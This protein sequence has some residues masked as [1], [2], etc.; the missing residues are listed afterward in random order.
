M[1]KNVEKILN[2]KWQQKKI[3]K[4]QWKKIA[5]ILEKNGQNISKKKKMSEN[6]FK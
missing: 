4:T 5:K 3:P 6:E 1:V 2:T